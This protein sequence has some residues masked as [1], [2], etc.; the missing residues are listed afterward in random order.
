MANTSTTTSWFRPEEFEAPDFDPNS[1]IERNTAAVGSLAFTAG[2]STGQA[3]GLSTTTT[4]P[5]APKLVTV[6]SLFLSP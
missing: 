6:Y 1:Y 5:L 3:H 4:F 2:L